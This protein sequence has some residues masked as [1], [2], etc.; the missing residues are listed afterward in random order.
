MPL[1]LAAVAG[2]GG[3]RSRTSRCQDLEAAESVESE[4]TGTGDGKN[5][6][7]DLRKNLHETI[8]FSMKYGIFL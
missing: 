4:G 8:D 2:T 1:K 5:H 6:W 7:V 3:K